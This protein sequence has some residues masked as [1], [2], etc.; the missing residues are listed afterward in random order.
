MSQGPGAQCSDGEV[1]SG[2]GA[3]HTDLFSSEFG[4]AESADIDASSAMD[5]SE[6]AKVRASSD[7]PSPSCLKSPGVH[8]LKPF[9]P[10]TTLRVSQLSFLRSTG[11][12]TEV[13]TF[14]VGKLC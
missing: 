8:V 14:L 4:Q 2:N 7:S 11:K 9:R 12:E 3:Q 6:P 10:E 5:T 13:Y 1:G